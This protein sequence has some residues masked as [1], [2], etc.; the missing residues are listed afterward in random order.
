[1]IGTEVPFADEQLSALYPNR[2]QYVSKIKRRLM[3]L[4]RDGWFLPQYADQVRD[5][6]RVTGIP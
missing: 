4:V 1:L 2:G 5:D 6:L 3:E